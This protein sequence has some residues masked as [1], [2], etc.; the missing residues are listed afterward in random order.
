MTRP[1]RFT[2]ADLE[3]AVKAVRKAGERVAGAK[4]ELDGSITVLT[5]TG[6][7]AN[8]RNP[9]DRILSR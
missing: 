2:S 5:G 9:L 1:S 3:R 7:A 8:D 6:Q 4:I